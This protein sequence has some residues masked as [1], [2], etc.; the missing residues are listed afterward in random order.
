MTEPFQLF[1]PTREYLLAGKAIVTVENPAG[2]RY[3]FKVR[4]K[5]LP[6]PRP[7]DQ[8][9]PGEEMVPLFFVSLLTGPDNTADYAYLGV[10]DPATGAVRTTAKSRLRPDS[11]PVRVADWACRRVVAGEAFPEGYRAYHHNR[12]GRCGRLLTVPE[13]IRSGLGPECAGRE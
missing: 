7:W 9:K 10:L 12:C 13:S 4:K 8:L 6:S 3:T 1:S 11:K 2:E 5:V